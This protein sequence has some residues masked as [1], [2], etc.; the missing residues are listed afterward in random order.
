MGGRCQLY[1]RLC[2]TRHVC[3]IDM[4]PGDGMAHFLLVTE[5]EGIEARYGGEILEC[6][7]AEDIWRDTSPVTPDNGFTE[8]S[9]DK[10]TIAHAAS[11]NRGSTTWH[12]AIAYRTRALTVVDGMG[13]CHARMSYPAQ[14][15][16]LRC[17]VETLK[18]VLVNV[19]IT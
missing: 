5:P 17:V 2:R 4:S 7:T 16:S 3:R 18:Y 19:R 13:G 6:E 15:G 8:A 12:R 14:R 9:R 1:S 11:C 10:L